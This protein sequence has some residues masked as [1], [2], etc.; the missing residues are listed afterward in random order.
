MSLFFAP[1]GYLVPD[2]FIQPAD[3][4]EVISI[5]KGGQKLCFEG[6]IGQ[7]YL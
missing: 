7:Y 1:F 2:Q 5:I 4:M 3:A 6:Q